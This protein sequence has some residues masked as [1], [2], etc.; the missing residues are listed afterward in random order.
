MFDRREKLRRRAVAAALLLAL[1]G[2]GPSGAQILGGRLPSLPGAPA[3]LPDLPRVTQPLAPI[4]GAATDLAG[5]ALTDVRRLTIQRLL[6]EHRDVVEAD[7]RGQPVVRGEVVALGVGPEALERLRQAGFT[8]RARDSLSSLGLESLTLGAP[9][10]ISAVEAVRRARAIDPAAQY[11]FDHLYQESGSGLVTAAEPEP[12]GSTGRALRIGMVDGS[13]AKSRPALARTQLVQHAFASGG[14]RTTAHAT[15]VASLIARADPAADIYVADVYGPT[16]AGGSAQALVRALDWL[17]QSGTP[18]IN[19]SLVGPPNLLLAAAVKAA[20][21]RGLLLVAPVGND[22]PAAPP[23]YPAAYPGVIAVTGVDAHRRV[24]PEAGRAGH[25]DFA[26]PGEVAAAAPG[27]GFANV[28]GTSYAAPIVAGRLAVLAAR[29]GP[30][31]AVQALARE[32]AASGRDPLFGQGLVG[33]DLRKA[34]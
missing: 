28:R 9:R 5:A 31:Q 24:L 1:A 19:I 26:G 14:A 15:A 23:L 16:P 2:G 25:V 22:G 20:T 27:G 32:V 17:A 33:F 8:V 7:D 4:T 6:R 10:G 30:S 3:G 11:D 34:P 13:A 12:A 29:D 21:S 18:V